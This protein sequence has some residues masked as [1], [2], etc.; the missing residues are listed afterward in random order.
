[1]FKIKQIRP[2]FTGVITTA[3]TYQ[4]ELILG[5]GIIDATKLGGTLNPYQQVVEVGAMV[6]DVKPGDIVYLNFNRY[7]QTKHVPGV[8]QDNI[9]SDNM[10]V[11]YS[12]PKIE[13]DGTNYL[14]VQVNDIEYVVTDYELDEGGLLQ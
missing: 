6:K 12:I 8:I 2:L 1:M 4:G 10:S 14:R 7:L 9:Q 5:S 3:R 11:Q 13:M